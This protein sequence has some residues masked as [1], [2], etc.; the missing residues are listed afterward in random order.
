MSETPPESPP[1]PGI[2]A[3]AEDWVRDHLAPDLAAV[4]ADVAKIKALAPELQKVADLALTLARTVPGI[5]P[6]VVADAEKAA[7]VIAGIAGELAAA[8]M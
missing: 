7:E 1:E 5:S 8:G 6:E 3:R 2:L 4:K